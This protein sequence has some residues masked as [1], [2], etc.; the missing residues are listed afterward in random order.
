[1]HT[2]IPHQPLQRIVFEV[3]VSTV[4]LKRIIGHTE[5]DIRRETFCHCAVLCGL[6]TLKIQRVSCSP[7]QEASGIEFG[8][9]VGELELERL[10]RLQRLSKLLPALHVC[11]SA[12]KGKGCSSKGAGR[13]IDAPPVQCFH[14]KL[15]AVALR[16]Q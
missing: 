10:E 8:C 1:M 7:D 6:G 4:Y 11:L 9:H 14:R 3:S 5:A 13:Y 16:N 2:Q 15:E 12:V